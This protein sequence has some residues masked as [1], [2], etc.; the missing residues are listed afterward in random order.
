MD[1]FYTKSKR[2]NYWLDGGVEA[3]GNTVYPFGLDPIWHMVP[4]ELTF[5]NSFKMKMS[6]VLGVMQMG[7]GVCLS[8]FNGR[9]FKVYFRDGRSS[10]RCIFNN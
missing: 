5:V 9:Y 3:Y 2:T 10:N 6:V 4:N 1:R 7:F 8:W